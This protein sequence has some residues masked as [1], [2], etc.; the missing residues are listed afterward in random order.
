MN[1][2]DDSRRVSRVLKGRA[3]APRAIGDQG[4]RPTP[5]SLQ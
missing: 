5:V 1:L 2:S 4:M 3:R